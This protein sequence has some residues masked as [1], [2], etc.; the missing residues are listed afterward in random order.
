MLLLVLNDVMFKRPTVCFSFYCRLNSTY[1][2]SVQSLPSFNFDIYCFI[3]FIII[4]TLVYTH[5]NCQER[6]TISF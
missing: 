2:I 1:L 6:F 3:Y 5:F 4:V